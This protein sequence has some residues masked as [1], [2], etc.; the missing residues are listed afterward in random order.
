MLRKSTDILP[1]FQDRITPLRQIH[2]CCSIGSREQNT[3]DTGSCVRT[4]H[5]YEGLTLHISGFYLRRSRPSRSLMLPLVWICRCHIVAWAPV[6]L[7]V[8]V[9]SVCHPLQQ[10]LP[11][12]SSC[13]SGFPVLGSCTCQK[14]RKCTGSASNCRCSLR[15][16]FRFIIAV[17]L[18]P[19]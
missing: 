10:T 9:P 2:T 4:T 14:G 19:G 18:E 12:G 15:L 7:I 17:R 8:A 3:C 1:R 13:R 5:K 16:G 6:A 11:A